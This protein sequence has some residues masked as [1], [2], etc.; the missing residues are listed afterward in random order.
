LKEWKCL[1]I[2]H[3][4]NV[5]KTIEEWQKNGWC[6]HA[7]SCAQVSIGAEAYHYLLFKRNIEV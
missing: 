6:L 3:H 7:Y 5:G 4:K 1:Q 2:K